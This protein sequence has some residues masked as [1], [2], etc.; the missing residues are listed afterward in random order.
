MPAALGAVVAV[1]V[2]SVLDT[3][4]GMSLGLLTAGVGTL[5]YGYTVVAGFDRGLIR[6]LQAEAGD[7]ELE[8]Q[9]RA[10][11]EALS[12]A[13]PSV[14]PI[15]G[16]IFNHYQSIEAVF[17]DGIDDAVEAVLVGSRKDLKELRDRAV[18][19]GKLYARL[20][21]VI[22]ASDGRWLE[23]EVGRADQQIKYTD[24]GPVRDA[25]VQARESTQRTL[26][27]WNTAIDKQQQIASVLTVIERNLQEFKMGM[28]LR[29]ADA[30]MGAG[31]TPDVSELQARLAAAGDACD[32][33]AGL[34]TKRE[35]RSRQR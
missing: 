11:R 34:K 23:T 31:P 6:Q 32:E 14:Q 26:A 19:L 29:K 10:L 15:L 17:T 5:L 25:L 30:A 1:G 2:S 18:Q 7:R 24:P 33:I 8:E 13:D 35:L 22:Q 27:Q 21:Q 16:A 12:S 9:E 28:E 3:D 20:G 4:V